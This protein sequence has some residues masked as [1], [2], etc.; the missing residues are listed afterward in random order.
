MN[1]YGRSQS[2]PPRPR[3]QAEGLP[4]PQNVVYRD[5]KGLRTALVDEEAEQWAKKFR[6]IMPSQ[7][8]RFYEH[9]SS[10]QRR[11]DSSQDRVR[12]FDE[13]RPEF[14][15]LKAKAA[16]TAGRDRNNSALLDLLQF[17]VNH[18]TAVKSLEDFNAFRKH[19]EAIIAFHKFYGRK[20]S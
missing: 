8:R 4:A 3:Q 9:V 18:T 20:E 12:C 16:Y 11:L 14:K 15:M 5:A 6:D 2:G 19:F 17:F 13:L 1:P 10:F 7:L